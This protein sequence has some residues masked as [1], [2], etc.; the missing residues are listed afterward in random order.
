MSRALLIVAAAT[1]LWAAGFALGRQTGA[2]YPTLGATAALLTAVSLWLL[3]EVRRALVP[4]SLGVGVADLL[5]GV[6]AGGASLLVTYLLYPLAAAS[7]PGLGVEVQGLYALAAVSGGVAVWMLVII[8]AEEVIWRGALLSALRGHRRAA[9]SFGAPIVAAIPYALAQGGSGSLWLVA[10]AGALGL[11]WG[12]LAQ[13]RGG[14]LVAPL[15]AHL[16]W[17]PVVLGLRPLI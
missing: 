7:F 11:A 2:L 6:F 16:L 15:V 5:V 13:L 1:V 14:R 9:V 4:P 8:V 10:A 12:G 3:P 17:T